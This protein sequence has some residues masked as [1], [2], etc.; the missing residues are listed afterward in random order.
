MC[1]K[2]GHRHY[3]TRNNSCHEMLSHLTFSRGLATSD[4]AISQRVPVVCSAH[5]DNLRRQEFCRQWTSRVEQFT[6]GTAIK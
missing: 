4:H 3:L 1:Q 6:C 5:K 2:T